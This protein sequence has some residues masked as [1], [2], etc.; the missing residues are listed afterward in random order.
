M[1]LINKTLVHIGI[2]ALALV[3][4][5]SN[6]SAV[7]R[8]GDRNTFDDMSVVELSNGPNYIDLN[9]DGIDDLIFVGRYQNHNAHSYD[10]FTVYVLYSDKYL[11]RKWYLVPFFNEKGVPREDSLATSEGADCMLR[12][13]RLLTPRSQRVA[14]VTI[15]LGA[16][17]LRESYLESEKVRFVVYRLK[18]DIEVWPPFYF[19]VERTIQGKAMHCDINEAFASELGIGDYRK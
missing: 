15:I 18:K 10:R 9:G 7:E 1:A 12:D 11:P 8:S 13:I 16:R 17:D 19:Q 4:P 2:F 3:F 14:P 5:L 6:P